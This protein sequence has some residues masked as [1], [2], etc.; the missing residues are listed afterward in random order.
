MTEQSGYPEA[1]LT[2]YELGL[3]E[4]LFSSTTRFPIAFKAWLV[5]YLEIDPPDL[6]RGVSQ[7]PTGG[8]ILW[9]AAALPTGFLAANAATASQTTYA[10]LYGKCGTRFNTGGEPAGTFRLPPNLPTPPT[11]TRWIIKT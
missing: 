3:L 4:R 8:I 11:N 5:K 10:A 2:D 7:V 9:P 1:D 6:T